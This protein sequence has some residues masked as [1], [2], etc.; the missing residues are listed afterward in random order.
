MNVIFVAIGGKVYKYDLVSRECL[1]EFNTFAHNHMILFDEDDKLLVSDSKQVRLWD[2]FNHK[3]EVPELV[4]V[5][6]API[7]I[8]QLKVNLKAETS[9]SRRNVFYYVISCG[10]TFK[11][12]HGRLELLLEGTIEVD[13]ITSIEFGMDTKSLFIGTAKGFVHQYELPSPKEVRDEYKKPKNGEAAQAKRIGQPI[14]IENRKDHNYRIESIYRIAGISEENFMALH[15]RHSGLWVW[16]ADD[17]DKRRNRIECPEYEAGPVIDQIKATAD[18]R[19]LVAGFP[20]ANKVIFFSVNSL[21]ATLTA[22]EP[23]ISVEYTSFESDS[24]LTILMFNNARTATLTLYA[25]QWIFE[26]SDT[27][28]NQL[29]KQD[30]QMLGL[31]GDSDFQ[32]EVLVK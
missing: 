16:N 13:Q 4:T 30:Q 2:F 23:K 5:L 31:D 20:L 8:E 9:G 11:V 27:D 14:R 12:Y 6:E 26:M 3:D 21:S 22:L 25:I 32:S 19:F 28:V 1:F 15:V 18:G 10:D 24:N 17:A 29:K 7:K